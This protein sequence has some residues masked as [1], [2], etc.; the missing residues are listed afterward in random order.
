MSGNISNGNCL[1]SDSVLLDSLLVSPKH[2]MCF[3]DI[4]TVWW[5]SATCHW[6]KETGFKRIFPRI[7]VPGSFHADPKIVRNQLPTKI[8]PSRCRYEFLSTKIEIRL[9]KTESIHWKSLE[10]SKETTIPPKAI[11]LCLVISEKGVGWDKLEAQVKKEVRLL[12][13]KKFQFFVFQCS[14]FF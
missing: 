6:I 3:K 12:P 7:Q 14:S 13:A 10:F 1:P 5:K 9:S 11:T 8:I 4:A 2:I